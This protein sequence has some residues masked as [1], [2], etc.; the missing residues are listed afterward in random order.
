MIIL[1]DGEDQGSR[2]KIAEAIA[3]AEKSNAIIYVILIADV[4]SYGSW[5]YSGYSAAKRLSDETGGRLINVGNNGKKLEAAFQQIQ[6]ELRTQ[7]IGSYTSTNAKSDG[8][9]RHIALSCGEGTHAQVRKGY[10][11][12]GK[13]E[14]DR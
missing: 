9:F 6:D 7:Y 12:P 11:A 8:T 2:T 1:T 4:G 3:A 14:G 10:Y 13:D 5:G